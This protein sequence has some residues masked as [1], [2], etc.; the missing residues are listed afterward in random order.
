MDIKLKCIECGKEFILSESEQM[1]FKKLLKEGRIKSYNQ[2]KR[3]LQCRKN[4]KQQNIKN[5]FQR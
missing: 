2:P 5:E 4:K 3:C 1:Y